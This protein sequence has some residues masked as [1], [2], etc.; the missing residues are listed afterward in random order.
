MKPKAMK[1]TPGIMRIVRVLRRLAKRPKER[2]IREMTVDNCGR[3][4]FSNRFCP[5]G[6]AK[7]STDETPLYSRTFAD[8][9]SKD[10]DVYEFAG[11]WDSLTLDEAKATVDKIWPKKK[12]A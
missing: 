7:G 9:K 12:R 10:K 11:Q 2:D 3:A 1:F 6:L 8:G 5:M 4:R